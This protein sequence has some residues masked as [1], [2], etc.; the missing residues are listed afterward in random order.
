VLGVL[1]IRTA[2]AH[3]SIEIVQQAQQ[4]ESREIARAKLFW[5]ISSWGQCQASLGCKS[6]G[7]RMETAFLLA[8]TGTVRSGG[9]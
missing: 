3:G 6:M 5:A 2:S 9:R 7:D 4:R 1:V 8:F